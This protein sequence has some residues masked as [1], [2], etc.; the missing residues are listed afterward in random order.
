M[1][2]INGTDILV[3]LNDV[4]IGHSVA[5]VLN[6]EQDLPDASSRDSLGWK[7]TIHGLRNASLSIGG[8]TDY[9]DSMNY[10]EFAGFVITRQTVTFEFIGGASRFAG[11]ASVESIEQL[12]NFEDVASYNLEL[13]VNSVVSLLDGAWILTTG[14]WVDSGIWIDS[15]VWID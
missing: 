11:S 10:N 3:T 5:L 13:K 6:L 15:D 12:A 14:F 1:A 7:E 9:N 4:T 8:L 2:T